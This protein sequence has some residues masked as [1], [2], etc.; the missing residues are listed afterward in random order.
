MLLIKPTKLKFLVTGTGRCG[1]VY[2]ARLLT[3]LGYMCGHEAVFD[4]SGEAAAINR[5]KNRSFATSACSIYSDNSW[6]S[7]AKLDSESSYMAAPFLENDI[8]S[9]T[10]II[11]IVRHPLKVISSHINEVR[12]F[13]Y[14]HPPQAKYQ[15][16]VLTHLPSILEI[17]NIT[18]RAC[19]YY[20]QWNKMIEEKSRKKALFHRVE[21]KLSPDL[22]NYLGVTIPQKFHNDEKTNS[23]RTQREDMTIA[24]IPAGAIK[25]EFVA[26]AEKYGYNLAVNV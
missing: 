21:N 12:F 25:D 5:L 20:I 4:Y 14:P 9:E 15:E 3:S 22:A 1:T 23:W 2:M 16:F 17:E 26:V 18:E 8:L 24:D 7:S 10:K 11:H 6:F 19:Y 13:E